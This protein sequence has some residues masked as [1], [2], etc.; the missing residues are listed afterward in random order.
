MAFGSQ[1]EHACSSCHQLYPAS[2]L[3]RYLWCLPCRKAVYR[4]GAAW[5]RRLG[6]ITSLAV[7]LYVAL[8]V[9]PSRRYMV[10]YAAAL[11]LT[12]VLIGRITVA[13]IQGYYR[14]KGRIEPT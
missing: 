6:I 4:R 1:T 8:A 5:G 13:L 3:D 9:H 2:D 7:G 14:A 12:Y 10:L 11:V